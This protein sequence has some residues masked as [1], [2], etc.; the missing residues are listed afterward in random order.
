MVEIANTLYQT[1][2]GQ[3]ASLA[4]LHQ[5]NRVRGRSLHSISNTFM[6]LAIAQK[7]KPQGDIL[8]RFTKTGLKGS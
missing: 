4:Q 1:F 3:I 2:D 7:I 8:T 5:M 6:M